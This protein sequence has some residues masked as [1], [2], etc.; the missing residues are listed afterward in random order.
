MRFDTPLN[1]YHLWRERATP[2]SPSARSEPDDT[3]AMLTS[4]DIPISR[5]RADRFVPISMTAA[6]SSISAIA[7]AQP[8]AGTVPAGNTAGDVPHGP[9]Y[10]DSTISASTA[11]E[12]SVRGGFFAPTKTV[13]AA[14][15]NQSQLLANY[16]ALPLH[17]ELN[18]GQIDARVQFFARGTGYS[19]FLDGKSAVLSLHDPAVTNRDPAVQP[20]PVPGGTLQMQVIGANAAVRA[21][22]EDELPGKVNYFLGNDPAQWRTD[23][24]TY[25]KVEYPDAYQGIDLSY[26]GNQQ[27]LEYDF[28]V[29]PGADPATIALKF[30]GADQP[31]IDGQGDLVLDTAGRTL[32]QHKPII[33]QEVNGVRRLI[34]GGYVLKGRQEIGFQIGDYDP[35]Q[36]L[37]IDPVIAYS[38]YLGGSMDDTGNAIAVD[39]AGNVYVTGDT[40]STNFPTVSPMQPTYGGGTS[41]VFVAKLDPRG[42]TLLYSTYLGGE[43]FDRGNGIAVDPTGSV[44]ITGK[45]NSRKFPITAGAFEDTFR[46]PE[47]DGFVTKISPAGDRLSYSTYLGG[48]DNDAA[49][50]IA[51]DSS[52]NAYVTGGTKAHDF[53]VTRSAYQGANNGGTNAFITELNATGTDVLYSTFLGGSF[54]D[55][56]DAIAV[57]SS[58]LVYV[59]GHTDSDD[60]PTKDALQA[61]YGGGLDDAFVAKLNPQDSG[62][63]S[64]VYSTYLGGS[65]SEKGLGIAVDGAG[66]VYLAGETSSSD[67]PVVNA[68]QP[69]YGG[70]T[71]NAFVAKIN[72]AGTALLFA[73][74]LGGGGD[75]R[76]SGLALDGDGNIYL[77][78]STSSADF[79][80]VNAIQPAHGG[81]SDA[82]VTELVSDGSA[83]V[84]STYLGGSGNENPYMN[85]VNSGALAVDA[86]GNVTVTGTTASTDFPTVNPIQPEL[87][88]DTNAFI[89]R[90]TNTG[91]EGPRPR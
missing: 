2:L 48:D 68:L 5:N 90:L 78:G 32:V 8:S 76:A 27:Q 12:T 73:T 49:I 29:K 45:S 13:T 33:Y 26:Y 16:G 19:L 87:H 52:G 15:P 61:V 74:Y 83:L 54:T 75:D 20:A 72:S 57:D 21:V 6:P 24:P 17:F 36:T 67:F 31:G 11:A 64:L 89:A 42:T 28:V 40:T 91:P 69:R 39:G 37:V 43:G 3:A 10:G 44:Y 4:L 53:P 63:D 9:A 60:F 38:T 62:D 58:G 41:N 14:A 50:A 55:R 25:A 23:I 35:T 56:G 70:G 85:G 86:A 59:A 80:T 84:Y 82:F 51:V 88:G 34:E 79:P 81:G 66:N 65:G 77:T 46:G 22:G 30:I 71:S 7:V 47:Y 18:Q 1:P